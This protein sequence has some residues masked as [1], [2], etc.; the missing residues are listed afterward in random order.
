MNRV[1]RARRYLPVVTDGVGRR[2]ALQG[3]AAGAVGLLGCRI[4]LEHDKET[5]GVDAT[6]ARDA[7][8]ADA[9]GDAAPPDADVSMGFEMCGPDLCLDLTHPDNTELR[10]V[11]GSR[12]IYA[13]MTRYVVVR[14]TEVAFAALSAVC[15]HG[16]CTVRYSAASDFLSCPCHGSSFRLDGTVIRGPAP[17]PLTVFETIYDAAAELVTVKL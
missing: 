1:P 9:T 12:V 17:A 11:E 15:T 10:L 5:S 16:A 3:I 14:T 6:A 7:N 8:E 2:E 13:N 4:S